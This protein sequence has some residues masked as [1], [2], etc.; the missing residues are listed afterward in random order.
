MVLERVTCYIAVSRAICRILGQFA[1][2]LGN[3]PAPLIEL[4]N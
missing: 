3:L 4:T 2:F 1:A